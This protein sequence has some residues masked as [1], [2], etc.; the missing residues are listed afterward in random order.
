MTLPFRRPPAAVTRTDDRLT[1]ALAQ[2]EEARSVVRALRI[3]VAQQKEGA[4]ALHAAEYR[5][6]SALNRVQSLGGMKP[7]EP[8]AESDVDYGPDAA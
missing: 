6:N 3:L 2:L 1:A 4:A 5:L 8:V 7:P